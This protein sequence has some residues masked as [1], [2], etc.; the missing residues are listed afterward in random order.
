[1]WLPRRSRA[2]AAAASRIESASSSSARP[3]SCGDEVL[4]ALPVEDEGLAGGS[5]HLCGVVAE[6]RQRAWRVGDRER[7]H[8]RPVPAPAFRPNVAGYAGDGR[9]L[10]A[11]VD[12]H[13]RAMLAD[14]RW[15]GSGT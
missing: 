10:S 3:G 5:A 4:P 11:E 8:R 1:M 6:V 14:G 12:L 2:T 15:I 7:R 13:G 9:S